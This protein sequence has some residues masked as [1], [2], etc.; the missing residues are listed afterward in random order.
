MAGKK[1][2]PAETKT[3]E[4][5]ASEYKRPGPHYVPDVDIIETDEALRLVVD[6]P[7][8]RPDEVEIHIEGDRLDI[9]APRH[10]DGPEGASALW[11]ES[12]E[13]GH[14]RRSFELDVDVE[15]DAVGADYAD[16]VLTL[17]LPKA[18]A[19]RAQ[20]IEVKRS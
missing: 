6:L 18:K 8:A 17:S 19:A 12:R 1:D 4:V 11:R 10:T 15:R 16:G 3:G 13:G 20:R 14:Y 7:G 2:L 9:Y 5:A